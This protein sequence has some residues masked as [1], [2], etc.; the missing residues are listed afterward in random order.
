V[1]TDAEILA[2][3]R[4]IVLAQADDECLWDPE[5]VAE[6]YVVQELRTLHRAVEGD[7]TVLA[8]IEYP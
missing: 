4:R 6:A 8:A 2:V 7:L 3:C 5:T 1:S